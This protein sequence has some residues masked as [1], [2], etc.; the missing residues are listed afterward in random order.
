[1]EFVAKKSESNV[2]QQD[3][4]YPKSNGRRCQVSIYLHD[5]ITYIKH[6]MTDRSLVY[7]GE[8]LHIQSLNQETAGQYECEATNGIDSSLKKSISIVFKGTFYAIF[9]EFPAS[10]SGQF[11]LEMSQA[12]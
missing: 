11:E 6:C 10:L 7:H 12:V 4:L 1:M 3:I 9:L 8:V 5:L 2:Q